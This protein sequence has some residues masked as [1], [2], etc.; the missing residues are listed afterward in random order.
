VGRQD[1]V[2]TVTD[3]DGTVLSVEALPPV[4]RYIAVYKCKTCEKV[5]S[6]MII[7]HMIQPTIH[8]RYEDGSEI[9]GCH[10]DMIG[11]KILICGEWEYVGRF[12]EGE[13]NPF[14]V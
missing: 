12:V 3:S 2:I 10:R 8:Y 6:G 7:H 13:E 9:T 11:E 1:T 4:P 14:L 5:V